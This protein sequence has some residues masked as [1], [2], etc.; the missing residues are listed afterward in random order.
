MRGTQEVSGV[1]HVGRGQVFVEVKLSV[2]HLGAVLECV[3]ESWGR[4]G[5]SRGR[6]KRERARKPKAEGLSPDRRRRRW[7][8]IES[9]RHLWSIPRGIETLCTLSI[10]AAEYSL[11]RPRT[12]H[13]RESFLV[14][15]LPTS[16]DVPLPSPLLCS[17]LANHSKH[18]RLEPPS[19]MHLILLHFVRLLNT[20]FS[21]N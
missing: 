18:P 7:L 8:R 19:N 12:S 3:G 1:T 6:D 2:R 17:S 13:F 16:F 5:R 15:V 21:L 4:G 11:S 20:N 14:V 9:I 10:L